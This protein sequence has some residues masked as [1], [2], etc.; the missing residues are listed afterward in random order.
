MKIHSVDLPGGHFHC[1]TLPQVVVEHATGARFVTITGLRGLAFGSR[2]DQPAQSLWKSNLPRHVN[3]FPGISIRCLESSFFIDR[4][5]CSSA[6]GVEKAALYGG[7]SLQLV[8]CGWPIF[9]SPVKVGVGPLREAKP[10]G[11]G[12][13]STFIGLVKT[14]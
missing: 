8:G 4:C 1:K 13:I 14:G 12:S 6:G 7:R 3:M 2:V 11:W 10:S 9:T 5:S